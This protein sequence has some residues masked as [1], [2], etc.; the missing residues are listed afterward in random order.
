[1]QDA[2]NLKVSHPHFSIQWS[3]TA[4][5]IKSQI[6][7]FNL[8]QCTFLFLNS[9]SLNA[10][11]VMKMGNCYETL[12]RSL[13]QKQTIIEGKVRVQFIENN[14]SCQKLHC[15]LIASLFWSALFRMSTT[16]EFGSL[17]NKLLKSIGINRLGQKK[18]FFNVS[19]SSSSQ[20]PPLLGAI[21]L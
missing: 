3:K 2:L 12:S 19:K 9:S 11:S 15:E 13:P 17:L 14:L 4:G 6:V 7:A 10:G 16:H 18:Y 8:L 21:D 5:L 1:M 20:W